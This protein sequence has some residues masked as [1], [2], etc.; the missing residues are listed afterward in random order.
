M[1]KIPSEYQ[2]IMVERYQPLTLDQSDKLLFNALCNDPQKYGYEEEMLA[3][4]KEHP[5]ASLQEVAAYDFSFYEPIEIVDDE[6]G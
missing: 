3:W 2:K 6:D 4:I 1:N 5:D